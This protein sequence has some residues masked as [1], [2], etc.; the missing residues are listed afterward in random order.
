MLKSAAII[1]IFNQHPRF[2]N[3]GLQCSKSVYKPLRYLFRVGR[4]ILIINLRA[5]LVLRL[6][7]LPTAMCKHKTVLRTPWI[8]DNRF[9]ACRTIIYK[10]LL[11]GLYIHTSTWSE[12]QISYFKFKRFLWFFLRFLYF[13][14]GKYIQDT[15]CFIDL[16]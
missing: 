16:H 9:R 12:F 11:M 13:M 2:S 6:S 15:H 3:I 10:K 1:Q 5:T 8:M 14:R 7:R 4:S